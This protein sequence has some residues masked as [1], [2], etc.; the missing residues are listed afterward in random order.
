[1][2]KIV[3]YISLVL[4]TSFAFGQQQLT[5]HFMKDLHQS[6]FTNPALFNDKDFSYGFHL[7]TSAGFTGFT[8]SDVIKKRADDSLYI[9]FNSLVN[10]LDSV[11]LNYF[12]SDVVSNIFNLKLKIRKFYL[13]LSATQK[14]DMRFSYPRDFAELVFLGNGGMIGDTADFSGI[15]F[16]F[17]HYNE[18]ALGLSFGEKELTIGGKLKLLQ[19]LSNMYTE[20]SNF[21]LYTDASA[22]SWTAKADYKMNFSGPVFNRDTTETSSTD[23]IMNYFSNQ[24]NLGFA[25]DIGMVYRP[26]SRALITAS[27]LDLGYIKWSSQ[28]TNVYNSGAQYKFEGINVNDFFSDSSGFSPSTLADSL[29]NLFSPDTS[30]DAYTTKF[31]PKLLF[32]GMYDLT[33]R[34]RFGILFAKEFGKNAR[35]LTLSLSYYRRLFRIINTGFVYTIQNNNYFTTSNLGMGASLKLGP[36]QTFFIADNVFSFFKFAAYHPDPKSSVYLPIP[37]EANT[38]TFSFGLNFVF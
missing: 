25:A 1:M 29:Y 13:T 23:A 15:G 8:Y 24:D 37:K 38:F 9:D 31:A 26:N 18:F 28:V 19:G 6:N 2:K 4:T 20:N 22:F 17:N 10:N 32:S 14:L 36:L 35:P 34:N 12:Y 27:L 21:T 11:N 33:S 30:N 3:I 5:M 16:D 7:G